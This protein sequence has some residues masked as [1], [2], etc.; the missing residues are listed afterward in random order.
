MTPFEKF[1]VWLAGFAELSEAPPSAEQW[2]LIRERLD[3]VLDT[4]PPSTRAV[5][6]PP[7][8]YFP[9]KTKDPRSPLAEYSKQ[10]APV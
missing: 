9:S 2:K 6:I 3:L 10:T 7:E 5:T 8:A 1:A 4:L